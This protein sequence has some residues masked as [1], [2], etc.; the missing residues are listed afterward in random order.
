VPGSA[1]SFFFALVIGILV[2][3]LIGW[4]V[5]DIRDWL[6][7][8]G[9]AVAPMPKA[10]DAFFKRLAQSNERAILVATLVDGRKV[11]GFWDAIEA[12]TYQGGFQKL[13]SETQDFGGDK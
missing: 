1:Q 12:F 10:W 11:G 2:P 4:F 8:H 3:A 13:S 6:A 5:V 7:Q 9:Y